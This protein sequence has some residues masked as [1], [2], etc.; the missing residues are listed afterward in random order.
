MTEILIGILAFLICMLIVRIKEIVEEVEEIKTV[1]YSLESRT[2][3]IKK[4]MEAL[5]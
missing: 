3:G 5:R 4:T 2:L 1:I